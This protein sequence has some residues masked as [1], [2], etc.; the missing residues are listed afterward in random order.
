MLSADISQET[1]NQ[2]ADVRFDSFD[3]EGRT[4][5]EDRAV[6]ESQIL[7]YKWTTVFVADGEARGMVMWDWG[8]VDL[9][10][11]SVLAFRTEEV[12]IQK[13][14]RDRFA[15]F[16]APLQVLGRLLRTSDLR[17]PLYW[18]GSVY[19]ASYVLVRDTFPNAKSMRSPGLTDLDRAIIHTMGPRLGRDYDPEDGTIGAPEVLP[20]PNPT[21][22]GKEH[23]EQLNDYEMLDPRWREGR[24]LVIAVHV[25]RA[26]IVPHVLQ[27]ALRHLR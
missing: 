11:R 9:P 23:R 4:R 25:R 1:K 2:L 5:Q 6:F 19:P 15:L 20:V 8:R 22:R 16:L 12:F 13:D 14:Y 24:L 18:T 26:L 21:P 27:G 3:I 17:L 7:S 10:Q